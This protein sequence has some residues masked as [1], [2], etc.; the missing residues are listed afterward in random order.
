MVI[1]HQDN[2]K[3]GWSKKYEDNFKKI[4]WDKEKSNKENK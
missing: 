3:V 1:K 2:S 4:N